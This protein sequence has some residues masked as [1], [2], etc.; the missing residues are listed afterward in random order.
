MEFSLPRSIVA[1]T[2]I[3]H[4]DDRGDWL[5]PAVAAITGADEPHRT[6]DDEP[7]AVLL[8]RFCRAHH[9]APV[10][11]P[12]PVPHDPAGIGG[13]AGIAA[14][15][16]GECLVCPDGLVAV[17]DVV[18]FGSV[19]EPGAMV[20]W[21]LFD[22]PCNPPL[23]T[24]AEGRRILAEALVIAVDA[25]ETMDVARWK[26]EAADDI[27]ELAANSV[28]AAIADLLPTGLDPRRKELLARAAR[29]EAIAHLALTD[30][31]AA[32]NTWQADQRGA[33]LRHVAG[34]ARQAMVA[35]S[36]FAPRSQRA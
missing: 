2:W 33:A 31:G 10:V 6:G 14:I 8:D 9:D 18:G 5:I 36:V 19:L 7:L 17:P 35:A 13:S 27:A 34:A 28:P 4:G 15:D 24:L 11:S 16:A 3:G 21:E 12:L 25:L 30:D 29:L 32:V 20:Q 26:P 1:A 23:P 22:Q